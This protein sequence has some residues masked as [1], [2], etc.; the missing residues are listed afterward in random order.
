MCFLVIFYCCASVVVV[1]PQY[2]LFQSIKSIVVRM[3]HLFLMQLPVAICSVGAVLMNCHMYFLLMSVGIKM[4]LFICRA[5]SGGEKEDS[6]AWLVQLQMQQCREMNRA[7]ERERD[8]MK[9]AEKQHVLQAMNDV[10]S[11]CQESL[12]ERGCGEVWEIVFGSSQPE[13]FFDLAL[14]C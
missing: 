8:E 5:S 3:M 13:R 4:C 11:L 10:D 2:G 12:S 6:Q 14:I 7:R 1:L 9:Y